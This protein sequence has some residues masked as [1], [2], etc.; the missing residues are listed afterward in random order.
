MDR[1][2][3]LR[4]SVGAPQQGRGTRGGDCAPRAILGLTGSDT[5]S[6]AI[7]GKLHRLVEL[8]LFPDDMKM[9]R[10]SPLSWFK[11]HGRGC[12]ISGSWWMVNHDC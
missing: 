3:R 8:L 4:G 11:L 12:D 9:K 5:L 10:S 7:W 2:C 1:T 6:W